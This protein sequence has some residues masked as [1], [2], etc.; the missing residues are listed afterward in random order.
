MSL[1]NTFNSLANDFASSLSSGL[2]SA[3]V[4]GITSLLS[5]DS[6][7]KAQERAAQLQFE[8][9]NKTYNI[10]RKDALQ[11]Y[12]TQKA[13]QRQLMYDQASIQKQGLINAGINTANQTGNM[14]LTVPSVNDISQSNGSYNPVNQDASAFSSFGNYLQKIS[15]PLYQAQLKNVINDS[16]KKAAETDKTLSE[17]QRIVK[18]LELFSKTFD[19]QVN[20]FSSTLMNLEK[21]G[22][23]KEAQGSKIWKDIELV[24]QQFDALEIQ[25]RINNASAD[26]LIKLNK[27]RVEEIDA[28]IASLKASTDVDVVRKEILDIEKDFKD[29]GIDLSSQFGSILGL[30]ASKHAGELGERVIPNLKDFLSGLWNGVKK[31]VSPW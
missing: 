21:D 1:K 25:N 17:K 11:D 30:F 20:I 15:D 7:A 12:E 22:Q 29:M 23:I 18:D 28:H 5:G 14:T 4:G 13:D 2:G 31:A 6:T 9:W 10:Q 26:D 16:A 19:T 3:V 8:N 27:K 24:K